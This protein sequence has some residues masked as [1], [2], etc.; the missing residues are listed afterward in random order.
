MAQFNK[1][2]VTTKLLQNYPKLKPLGEIKEIT[3][4]KQSN[5]EGY[6]RLTLVKLTG[7]NGESGFL[8]AEDL[9]LTI[10]PTGSK[11]KSTICQIVNMTNTWVFLSGRGYGHGV[12]MCQCGAQGMAR[13]GK[14]V[15]EIL[16]YYYPGSKIVSVY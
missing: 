5:Y 16:L 14:T 13:E 4:A 8:R 10:D 2:D 3:P 12:G 6:S 9:R 15:A 1:A 11:L 7:S